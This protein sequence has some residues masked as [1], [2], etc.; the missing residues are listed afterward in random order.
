MGLFKVHKTFWLGSRDLVVMT[1]DIVENPVRQG[2]FLDVPIALRGPGRVPI[3]SL[4]LVRFRGGNEE[5]AITVEYTQFAS[6][7]LL[8][9]SDLEGRLLEVLG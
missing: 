7:P 4:E 9:L 5:L 2:M 8:E 6:A 1:G 3:H